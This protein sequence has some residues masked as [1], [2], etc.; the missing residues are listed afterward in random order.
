MVQVIGRR[1]DYEQR[2]AMTYEEWWAWP[3]EIT[4]AEWVDGIGIIFPPQTTI[5]AETKG[6]VACLVMGYADLCDLGRTYLAPLEMRLS[7]RSS[8][9]PDVLFIAHE[10]TARIT[11]LRLE[12]PADLV[13]EIVDD[14]SVE[15]DRVEKL[16]EYAAAGIPEYWLVDPRDDQRQTAFYQLT[17]RGDYDAV[18]LDADGRYHSR[19]LPGFWLRP[20]WFWRE[21]RPH[22]LTMLAAIAP[23]ALAAVAAVTEPTRRAD[24]IEEDGGGS[25]A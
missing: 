11:D 21:P 20:E 12:G 23:E 4:Q 10:H 22:T 13:I 3:G 1:P 2:I 25:G 16:A 8:R 15:R 19:V 5:H 18:A 24:V 6:F 7:E 9:E 14:D 17:E